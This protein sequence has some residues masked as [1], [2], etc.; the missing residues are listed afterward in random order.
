MV[1]IIIY[2]FIENLNNT[3]VFNFN[4]AIKNKTKFTKAMYRNYSVTTL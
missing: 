1:L 2:L 3:L 4:N